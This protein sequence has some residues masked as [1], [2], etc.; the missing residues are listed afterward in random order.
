MLLLLRL[1]KR[2]LAPRS[3]G[4]AVLPRTLPV[5]WSEGWNPGWA[6]IV[7]PDPVQCRCIQFPP[8]P[9]LSTFTQ[10]ARLASLDVAAAKRSIN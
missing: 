1:D 10:I 5:G 4:V 7:A 8:F 9:W 2:L 6:G 3:I